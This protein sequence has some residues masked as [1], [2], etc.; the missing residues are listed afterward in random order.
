MHIDSRVH[1]DR[2]PSILDQ[3]RSSSVF[4]VPPPFEYHSSRP[5][6]YWD[7]LAHG[8]HPH[9]NGQTEV[10]EHSS[11]MQGHEE[12]TSTDQRVLE[13]FE[14]VDEMSP[15]RLPWNGSHKR[16]RYLNQA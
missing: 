6:S 9:R 16:G 1:I 5:P 10:A 4:V 7:P 13:P 14:E 11:R 2:S 12:R 3:L 8:L 15:P